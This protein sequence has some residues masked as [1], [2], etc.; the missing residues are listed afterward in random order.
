LPE[1]I[2]SAGAQKGGSKVMLGCF[3]DKICWKIRL[4]STLLQINKIFSANLRDFFLSNAI[5]N[6]KVTDVPEKELLCW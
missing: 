5:L 1:E 6:K 2:V 4:T 3:D